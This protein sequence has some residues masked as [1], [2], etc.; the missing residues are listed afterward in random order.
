M[1]Q[2]RRARG[3]LQAATVG[4]LAYHDRRSRSDNGLPVARL[5]LV[6]GKSRHLGT[7]RGNG[8][9]HERRTN[10]SAGRGEET[11]LVSTIGVVAS[12]RTAVPSVE[13]GFCKSVRGS[14][15]PSQ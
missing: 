12:H 5:G 2:Q 10:G 15:N 13:G 7:S 9:A 14:A 11:W 6:R 8:A 3:G 4:K 1:G